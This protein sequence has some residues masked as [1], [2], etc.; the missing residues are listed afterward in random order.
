LEPVGHPAL[1]LSDPGGPFALREEWDSTLRSGDP[2][3]FPGYAA[4]LSAAGRES[5]RTGLADGFVV[6]EGDFD[7]LGGSMGLVHGERVVRAFDRAV[8]LGLPVVA[9]TRSGGARMHEGM[10]ALTQMA[11]TAAAARRHERAGLLSVAVHLSPTTGGVFASYSSLCQVRVAEAGATIGF[12]GPRVV[13][14]TTGEPVDGSHTAETA[15]ANGLVDAVLPVEE[16]PAWVRG[17]LGIAP[18]DGPST[19]R[20]PTPVAPLA[21]PAEGAWGEVERARSFGRP[22]G[23]HVARALVTSWTEI[24]GRVDPALRA[25]LATVHGQ[26]AVVVAT[27]RYAGSGRPTPAGYRLAQRA[28][29]L[30][31]N[32]GLPVVSLVD[33]PGAEPGSASENDGMAGEIARTFAA[34][35]EVPTPTV[36][37]CV[38]EGGSG[39]A[40]ALAAADV[41]LIQEHAIFSV[42]APE[43]AAAILEHDA[44]KASEVAPSL[45]LTSADVVELGVVDEVVPDTVDAVVDAVARLLVDPAP[46]TRRL[47]R[48]DAATE[49]WLLG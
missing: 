12:A 17:A 37:V 41:L 47:S 38:G 11:R 28:F 15:L 32:L 33:M 43:G 2:L 10:V 29:R 1:V 40:L 36:A 45:R 35:L 44:G 42:I 24:G 23:T 18:A 20:P 8:E 3:S 19:H 26:R 16:I 21:E 46:T 22:S 31:G 9:I 25:G 6:I 5:V 27:D 30:A 48:L 49:R 7:V 14:Q 39:G 4:K 13:E 34:L